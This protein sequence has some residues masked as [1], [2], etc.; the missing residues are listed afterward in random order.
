[1]RCNDG[2][3]SAAD[4]LNSKQQ[5][6]ADARDI[7]ALNGL[8]PSHER[9]DANKLQL[10]RRRYYCVALLS[11]GNKHA[12]NWQPEANLYKQAQLNTM[13][14]NKGR[15]RPLRRAPQKTYS[16]SA[17][18]RRRRR[19]KVSRTR[20][21]LWR[22]KIGRSKAALLDATKK[23]DAP[24]ERCHSRSATRARR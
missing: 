9:V 7:A 22:R 17:W 2:H 15:T 1:V 12:L 10:P 8:D 20:H 16:Q 5:R 23:L 13:D 24:K 11:I 14:S 4:V 19:W 21:K 6:A 18:A 3:Q